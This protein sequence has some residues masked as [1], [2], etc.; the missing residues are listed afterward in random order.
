MFALSDGLITVYWIGTWGTFV[1]VAP[2]PLFPF[3]SVVA[4][5]SYVWACGFVAC[6]VASGCACCVMPWDG[7]CCGMRGGSESRTFRF[8]VLLPLIKPG[9]AVDE[10]GMPALMFAKL[11]TL[12][13]MCAL[14]FVM[15]GVY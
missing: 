13:I 4:F 7:L 8:Q 1:S 9:Y 2:G 10:K 12:L 5:G 3:C 15:W 11:R 6:V 14:W